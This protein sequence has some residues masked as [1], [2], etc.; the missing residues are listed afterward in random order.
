MAHIDPERWKKVDEL[1]QRALS[2]PQN[3]RRAFLRHES[4]GD[5]A[6]EEEVESLLSAND[7][8]GGFLHLPAIHVAARAIADT[9]QAQPSSTREGET[10]S[11]YRI[12]QKLGGG[13]MGIVYK[14]EDTEL[15]RFVALKFLPEQFAFDSQ[16]LE[17]FRREARAASALNHPNI[18]TIYEIGSHLGQSFIVMEFLEGATL[19][20]RIGGRPMPLENLLPLAIEMADALDAAHTAGIVHRDIKPANIFVTAREHAKI[21]D[22]G[23]AKVAPQH[24]GTI[25][26]TAD[27]RLTAP[28]SAMGTLGYM[29]P[30]Q[31]RGAEVDARTDLFSFGAVLYEMATGVAAFRGNSDAEIIDAILNREPT[32]AVRLNFDVPQELEHVVS[33]ALEKNRN[34]RYQHASEMR[35]D[36]ERLRRDSDSARFRALPQAALARQPVS[37]GKIAAAVMLVAMIIAALAYWHFRTRPK[38]TDKDTVVQAAAA[39]WE[40]LYGNDSEATRRAAESLNIAHGRD[41]EFATAFALARA[42]EV[43]RA[44]ELARDLKTRFPEDTSV[45]F[46]YLPTLDA[47]FALHEHDP[48]KALDALQSAGPNDIV[49]PGIDFF[50]FFGGMYPAYVGGE[51]YLAANQ[52]A[53]AAAE[54][55][56]VIRS[57]RHRGY[58]SRGCARAS[59]PCPG[60]RQFGTAGESPRALLGT[61]VALERCRRRLCPTERRE[62]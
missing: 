15:G 44:Q 42:G 39:V 52:P 11:H 3:E 1:L 56:K 48:R 54:F 61:A 16:A 6:L 8:A 30:E 58:G 41:V 38:L 50:D 13:G 37:I 55:Q 26:P 62:E 31:V 24:G 28:G 51:A 18:C 7:D 60:I 49:V 45:R 33:K 59:R 22:F 53:N 4:G 36:L 35:A 5:L 47:L 25:A 34:L 43:N 19:K 10:V 40:S 46:S 17:R 23:L 9:S 57:P 29:S 27:E 14:A 12:L 32:T 21:L 20:H 2:V